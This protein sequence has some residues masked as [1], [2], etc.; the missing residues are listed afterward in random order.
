[1][2][3]T[4]AATEHVKRSYWER[5]RARYRA[6]FLVCTAFNVVGSL[7]QLGV[8]D[9]ATLLL[10]PSPAAAFQ[11]ALLLAVQMLWGAVYALP[12]NLIVAA[13]PGTRRR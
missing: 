11:W 3:Q 9:S 10:S 2:G 7:A 1:M 5:Y 8:G 6:T 13:F 12:V 4:I